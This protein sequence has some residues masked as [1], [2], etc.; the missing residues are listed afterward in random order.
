MDSKQNTLDGFVKIQKRPTNEGGVYKKPQLNSTIGIVKQSRKLSF[1]STSQQTIK[2]Q[3][4]CLIYNL[5]M[6]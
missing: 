1:D 2:K 3:K 5:I 6:Y 4:V